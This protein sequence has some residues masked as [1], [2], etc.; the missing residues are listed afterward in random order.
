MGRM[1]VAASDPHAGGPFRPARPRGNRR[2]GRWSASETAPSLEHVPVSSPVDQRFG[3]F[4]APA[5]QLPTDSAA[6]REAALERAVAAAWPDPDD[7]IWRYSRIE[8]LALE[9]FR[10]APARSELS[11]D[12]TYVTSVPGDGALDVV[13]AASPDVFHD[14]NTAYAAPIRVV[15][16]AGRVA[17]E[18]LVITHHADGVGAA[19]MPRLLIE[20]GE[21]SEITVVERFRGD[22]ATLTLPVVQIVAG[23]A[24]RVRYLAVNE[25][26]DDAWLIGH[27]QAVGDADS[28]VSIATV[29]LGGHYARFRTDARVAGQGANTRQTALY[30]AAG[31]QMH[32]FR[33]LQDHDAPR[34]TSN[35]L[36]KGAVQDDSASV[37]TGLI[38]VRPHARGT[39]AF[40]TN[41]NLTLGAGAWAQSVPNLDIQTNEVSCSHASTVGPVDPEHRFYLESRGVPTAVADRLIVIGFFDEVLDQLP[42]RSVAD[43]VRRTI[44]DKLDLDQVAASAARAAHQ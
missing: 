28:D 44:V 27:Q 24:A 31:E 35:L 5:A 39:A 25:V 7:E 8:E 12:Q 21:D 38:K 29:S 22:G 26:A 14:L 2:P 19:V 37:Y 4:T 41:R 32:D 9:R 20:A 23:R 43:E 15:V 40:Q 33:T 30:F 6:V 18:P 13:D 34:A 17:A 10:P 1:A 3:P 16:P 11:G 36:F 42:V